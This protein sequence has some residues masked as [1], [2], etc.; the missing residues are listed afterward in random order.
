MLPCIFASELAVGASNLDEVRPPLRLELVPTALPVLFGPVLPAT[1]VLAMLPLVPRD[2]TRLPPTALFLVPIEEADELLVPPTRE[3]AVPARELGGGPFPIEPPAFKPVEGTRVTG[4]PN[5]GIG[6]RVLLALGATLGGFNEARLAVDPPDATRFVMDEFLV[7][8]EG[9][10][11][12]GEE[13]TVFLTIGAALT[14]AAAVGF[15]TGI[16]DDLA[17]G[18][19]QTLCTSDLAEE[20]NPNLEVDALGFAGN[21]R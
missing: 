15:D 17:A 16:L 6:E 9:R 10:A 8:T 3:F 1:P 4:A 11:T 21:A 7:A 13:P 19:P 5:V 18:L 12:A 14:A 2:E 20:R